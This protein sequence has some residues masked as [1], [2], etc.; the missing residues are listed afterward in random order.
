[1]RFSVPRSICR[2]NDIYPLTQS[3]WHRE[4]IGRRDCPCHTLRR[5]RLSCPLETLLTENS[6]LRKSEPFGRLR[7]T[8]PSV[9]I[10][11]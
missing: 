11:P 4:N 2:R 6:G 1:M 3:R 10:R 7:V 8:L 5:I 9:P